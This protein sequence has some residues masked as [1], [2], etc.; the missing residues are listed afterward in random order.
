[1]SRISAAVSTACSGPNEHVI[2]EATVAMATQFL[3]LHVHVQ[4]HIRVEDKALFIVM[5]LI[6]VYLCR[7]IIIFKL[8]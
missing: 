7:Y 4:V 2:G 1:M 5:H 6:H 8:F 3:F